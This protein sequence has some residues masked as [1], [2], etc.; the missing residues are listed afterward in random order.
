MPTDEDNFSAVMTTLLPFQ[1]QMVEE[2]IG[3]DGMCVMS[4]GMGWQKAVAVILRLHMERR[5]DASQEG[6]VL[7][8]GC[9]DWQRSMLYRE[10]HRM[11]DLP[12][13]HA[14]SP[15]GQSTEGPDAARQLIPTSA[16]TEPELL[17]PFDVTNEV[18][19]AGRI[20]LYKSKPCLFV[21]TRIL[22]VDMLNARIQGQHIA[23]MVIM[24]AHRVTDASGEAFAVRLFRMANK[25]GFI[26][27]FSD[28]PTGF[29]SGFNKIEKTMKALYVR[30]LFLWPR[31]QGAVKDSLEKHEC[32]L[33]E[34]WLHLSPP[35]S[36]IYDAISDLMD[37]CVKE[38]RK[39]NKIDTS[40]LTLEHGLFKSFDDI[41]R[42]QLDS[43]WHTVSPKTKQLVQDLRTLRALAEYLLRFDSVT[44]LMYLE[45]L[46]ATEGVTSV[47]LFH[48][49]AH[50]IFEQAKRRVYMLQSGGKGAAGK[51]KRSDNGNSDDTAAGGAQLEAVLEEM[52]KWALVQEVLQEIQQERLRMQ[53]DRLL[54][55][56]LLQAS[57][58]KAAAAKVLIV[59]QEARTCLQLR[60]CLGPG[61]PAALMQE[62]FSAYLLHRLDNK[63][64]AGL[65]GHRG[66]RGGRGRSGGRR[67]SGREAHSGQS[68]DRLEAMRAA[69]F[70][71]RGATPH[72][73]QALLKQAKALAA[74][75]G[76]AHSS[77]GTGSRSRGKGA[78]SSRPAARTA[79]ESPQPTHAAP[80]STQPSE[81]AES[82]QGLLKDVEF[83]TLD[84]RQESILWDVQ[85]IFVV[86]YDP[87]VTFV[88][89]LEIYQ[90][91]RPDWRV[92]VYNLLYE[93]SQEADK[94]SAAVA[95]EVR[96]FKDLIRQKEHMVLPDLA[97][98]LA[99]VMVGP[100]A[101][102]HPDVE[103][104]LPGTTYNA[105]TRRA[106][107]RLSSRPL[108]RRLVIDV[109]E[110]M[111]SL[112]SV[113]HQQGLHIV[114]VTLEVGDYILSPE[115]CVERKSI[116]DLKGS[117]IS[118]RLYHQ[119]E[120]MS[121]NYKTPILLIEFERDKA[122]ALHSVSEISADISQH[123]LISKLCLLTLHFPRLR[124][125]WSRSLH[126]TADIFRALKTNQDE[127]DPVSAA[128]VGVPLEGDGLPDAAAEAVINTT[129]VDVL[130]RLPGVTEA[131]F[132]PLINAASSLAGLADLPL[133]QLERI[134]G[135]AAAAKKLREWLDAVCPVMS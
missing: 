14:V 107:G 73:E 15:N 88:R 68:S 87:D 90:A 20:D 56:D 13:G 5:R 70:S 115:M 135:G 64:R 30:K 62:L 77:R 108:P 110:F 32:E 117:F 12:G 94:F 127:P 66:G 41:V 47:W 28:Q 119:A 76:T 104:A 72:E 121:R 75:Q 24:N 45:N 99:Q 86:V 39:S 31:Y 27:A 131:N 67:S 61:G 105:L 11:S 124:I 52:P 54:D 93:D 19:A 49:A 59:A 89:Q 83:Y 6:V 116:S 125:I 1:R 51:R 35:M 9:T 37:S 113:L 43:V 130:R 55:G 36:A 128:A 33:V 26:R 103:E 120:A 48:D 101:L 97:Q 98:D 34:M 58:Q 134:M 44:F 69:Q 133:Q 123:S 4:A 126:A 2:L 53:S 17:L 109:R 22:V 100:K 7:V 71:S 25:R 85:P 95:R 42:R 46:R 84:S 111:S 106:G 3:E 96:M 29:A 132:R 80:K 92:R 18:S 82:D 122:F 16:E 65:P 40:Q 81:D 63:A 21:T 112:P 57:R 60:S 78:A 74:Q 8:L 118:G 50:T 91:E 23:G 79:P 10:L 114:P 102:M 38:L 129:A